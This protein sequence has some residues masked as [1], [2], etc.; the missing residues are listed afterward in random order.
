[1]MDEMAEPM[2]LFRYHPDPISTG[3]VVASSAGCLVCG[4]VRGFIYTGPVYALDEVIDGLCPWCIS[5]GTAAAK[6]D[7]EFTDAALGAPREIPASVVDELCHRTPG[8]SSWQ[9]DRW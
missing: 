5:D 3:S 7:A 8:Y 1:M 6:F 2:P 9:Q 4:L